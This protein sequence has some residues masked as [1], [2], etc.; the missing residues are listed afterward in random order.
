MLKLLH[1]QTGAIM[2]NL[3]ANEGTIHI[4]KRATNL[5]FLKSPLLSLHNYH[6]S[7]NQTSQSGPVKILDYRAVQTYYTQARKR[8]LLTI[9]C[10]N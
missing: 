1:A 7:R 10:T 4:F 6:F 5:Y 2:Y 8:Y 9:S 3:S